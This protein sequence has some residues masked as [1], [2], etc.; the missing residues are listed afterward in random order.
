MDE[1]CEYG[2]ARV[3]SKDQNL[4]RQ[5][6]ALRAAG[7]DEGR[8]YADKASGKDFKRPAYKRVLRKL[9]SGDVLYVKSIDRLGRNYTEIIDEWRRITKDKGAHIVVLDMPLLDTR[10]STGGITGVLITDIVLQLLSYV[11]QVERENIKQ[12]QAEG[13]ASAKARGVR[14]GRPPI[15]RPK[16][17]G[18]TKGAFLSGEI[19][20][21]E[22]AARLKVSIT[23]FDKWMTEDVAAHRKGTD[24]LADA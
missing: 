4:A 19:T 23:T 10:Q 2:Y 14:F 17:Y 5:M 18:K 9:K 1:I 20:R 13:I 12:R 21:K 11:A 22:A 3:S 6:D 24:T 15:K 8:I 7:L 16:S